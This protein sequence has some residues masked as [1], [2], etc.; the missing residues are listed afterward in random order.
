MELS[1]AILKWNQCYTYRSLLEPN[2]FF[3]WQ[4][5]HD[6]T[7]IINDLIYILSYLLNKPLQVIVVSVENINWKGSIKVTHPIF[8]RWKI[9]TWISIFASQTHFSLHFSWL[10]TTM[11]SFVTKQT[12]LSWK[13]SVNI[14]HQYQLYTSLSVH[15]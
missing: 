13:L 2:T 15:S 12:H 5:F 10:V 9:L 11:G 6:H 7:R 1:R 14:C 8:I 3:F 4:H